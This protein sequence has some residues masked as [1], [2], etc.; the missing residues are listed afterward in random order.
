M[1]P[2]IGYGRLSQAHARCPKHAVAGYRLLATGY[3]TEFFFVNSISSSTWVNASDVT[4]SAQ[5]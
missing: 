1:E 3:Y 4:E 5:P 2:A